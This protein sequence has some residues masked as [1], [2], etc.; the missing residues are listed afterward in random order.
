M[1]LPTI[2]VVLAEN[3]RSIADALSK[4]KSCLLVDTSR[5]TDKLSGL[6]EMYAGDPELR[7]LLTQ[8]A[9]Q[10]CDGGGAERIASTF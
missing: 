1:G 4:Y 3:Q 2:M 9:A 5:I 6:V 10:I 8:N 7:L